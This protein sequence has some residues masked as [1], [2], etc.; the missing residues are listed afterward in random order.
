MDR[1]RNEITFELVTPEEIAGFFS[2]DIDNQRLY[3]NEYLDDLESFPFGDYDLLFT[4]TDQFGAYSNRKAKVLFQCPSSTW[5][6]E[7]NV[8]LKDEETERY[9]QN[10]TYVSPEI[11]KISNLG[12]VTVRVPETFQLS[13]VYRLK[14]ERLIED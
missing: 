13:P 8:Q 1:E 10:F 6:P 12:Q 7:Y 3:L 9:V 4:L 2:V 11:M 14:P 5:K